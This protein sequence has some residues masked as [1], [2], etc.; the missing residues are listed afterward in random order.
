MDCFDRR[1]PRRYPDLLALKQSGNQRSSNKSGGSCYEYQWSPSFSKAIALIGFF[2]CHLIE[3]C[4]ANKNAKTRK[5]GLP[6]FGNQPAACP[7]VLWVQLFYYDHHRS[8]GRGI[9][10]QMTVYT[11][12]LTPS[13][14]TAQGGVSD[15]DG[16]A[17][18]VVRVLRADRSILPEG[19]Q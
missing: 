5:S 9:S 12:I 19:R 10:C 4:P 11:K 1:G 16:E 7:M 8:L 15:A 13:T 6:T 17:R 18:A 2:A 14:V 3:N